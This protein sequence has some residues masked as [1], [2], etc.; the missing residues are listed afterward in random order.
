MS[1][2]RVASSDDNG[3]ALSGGVRGLLTPQFE[4]RGS[5]NYINVDDSD[6]YLE[7]AGDYYFT[8]QFSAGLSLEFAGDS[9]L[10]SIGAR[11]YFQ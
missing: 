2:R 9:D 8:R 7:L 6:T 5:V 11:Y 3:V 4:I 1:T 10:F